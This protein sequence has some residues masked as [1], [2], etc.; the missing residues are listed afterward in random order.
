M[1]VRERLPASLQQKGGGQ[2]LVMRC[3]KGL[4]V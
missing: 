3:A 2:H 4:K 1:M